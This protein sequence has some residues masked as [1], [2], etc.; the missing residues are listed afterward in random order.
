M[1][2]LGSKR[3]KEKLAQSMK[4]QNRQDGRVITSHDGRF[5]LG[6]LQ[7]LLRKFEVKFNADMFLLQLGE[8][9][10]KITRPLQ[11]ERQNMPVDRSKRRVKA[12]SY[13]KT[14]AESNFQ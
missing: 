1:K 2:S 6:S 9:S 4:P 7:I 8:S 11:P 12:K 10:S 14:T 13:S 5:L 3:L